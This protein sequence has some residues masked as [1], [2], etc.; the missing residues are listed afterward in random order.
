LFFAALLDSYMK[1][2]VLPSGCRKFACIVCE[3]I[4]NKKDNLKNHVEAIHI[5]M[6]YRCHYPA[7]DKVCKSQPALRGHVRSYHEKPDMLY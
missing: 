1:I 7:C 6:E 2:Q 4:F 5:Q 3:K